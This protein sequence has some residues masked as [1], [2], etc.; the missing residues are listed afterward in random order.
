M[1]L[2]KKAV[3][4][5]MVILVALIA[6][7]MIIDV[8]C[9]VTFSRGLTAEEVTSFEEKY[10]VFIHG[11]GV[12]YTGAQSGNPYSSLVAYSEYKNIDAKIGD[13]IPEEMGEMR[14][15]LIFNGIAA[16]YVMSPVMRIEK[17][18]KDELIYDKETVFDFRGSTNFE[19]YPLMKELPEA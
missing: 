8:K 16:A 13:I 12:K 3:A 9:T 1:K 2:H 17:I 14:E 7:V 6:A 4:V 10:K 11:V 15:D 19:A 5:I 18:Q